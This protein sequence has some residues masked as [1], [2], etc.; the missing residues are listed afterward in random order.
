MP[1]KGVNGIAVFA[2]VGGGI[3][4]Y[5]GIQGKSISGSI[6]NVLMGQSPS[7]A[8]MANS[9]SGTPAGAGTSLTAAEI[10]SDAGA[11]PPVNSSAAKNQS[12][13]RLLTASYGWSTGA[14][15]DALVNLWTRESSWDNNAQNPNSTAYGIAQFLDTTWETVGGTKTSNPTIQIALGLKYIKNRYGNPA[16]AW[17]HEESVGWY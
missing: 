15:W 17:A 3:L 2:T 10:A 14:Q 1:T 8:T 6:R 11:P 16:N 4:L 12:I 13:A 5:S 9:I 7:T